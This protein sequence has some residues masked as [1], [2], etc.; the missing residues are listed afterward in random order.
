MVFKDYKSLPRAESG[1]KFIA[2]SLSDRRQDFLAKDMNGAPIFLLHDASIPRYV[3]S[4]QF[5]YLNAQFHTTCSV[6]VAGTVIQDQFAV[7]SCDSNAPDLYELFIKCFSAA[8]EELPLNSGTRELEESIQGL[9]DLFR[10]MSTPSGREI[11]GLWAELFIIDRSSDPLLLLNYWH[12]DTYEK[13]DFS[14]PGGCLEI[15]STIRETRAH[16]FSMAQLQPPMNGEGYVG[17]ILMQSLSGGVS[18]IDLA[19]SIDDVASKYPALRKKL[20]SNI[21]SALGND[22]SEKIDRRF[23]ISFSERNFMAFHMNDIPGLRQPIDPRITGIRYS[24]S[25]N[26][27]KS[28]LLETSLPHLSTLIASSPEK[29]LH[30][31]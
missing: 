19:N 25:L 2:L 24:V 3:P 12:S 29:R 6:H 30:N 16:E 5:L 15:K 27:V 13:F 7:I 17:S 9:L 20:W 23:D 4:I 14:W 8:I 22:F 26:D 11:A 18:I 10:V 21:A 1:E 28:S 31:V